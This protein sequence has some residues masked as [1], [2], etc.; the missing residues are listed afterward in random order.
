MSSIFICVTVA[1]PPWLTRGKDNAASLSVIFLLV[2][3]VD[4][5]DDMLQ[6]HRERQ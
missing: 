6:G 5:F 2:K 3:L 4:S 1:H